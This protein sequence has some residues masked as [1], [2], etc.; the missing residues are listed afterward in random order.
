MLSMTLPPLLKVAVL[1][2]SL[3]ASTLASEAIPVTKVQLKSAVTGPIDMFF[4]AKCLKV[5]SLYG[6]IL[7]SKDGYYGFNDESKSYI[8]YKDAAAFGHSNF[9]KMYSASEFSDP[10]LKTSKWHINKAVTVFA[11]KAVQYE[12]EVRAIKD[13]SLFKVETVTATT[14][15]PT[16]FS[17]SWAYIKTLAPCPENTFPLSV[18]TLYDAHKGEP[19]TS[20][21]CVSAKKIDKPL[22]FFALPKGYKKAR[23]D[24]EV[25]VGGSHFDEIFFQ[26]K[27]KK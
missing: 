14:D 2:A 16:D 7:V 27:D 20:L 24:I 23:D 18:T 25:F 5:V 21:S 3:L 15:L 22:S 11:L 4:S 10:G 19:Q 12:R 13:N 1:I 8:Q 9:G 17:L 26:G 6:A